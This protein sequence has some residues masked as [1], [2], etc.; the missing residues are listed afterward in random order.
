MQ[1]PLRFNA[2]IGCGALLLATTG[3]AANAPSAARQLHERIIVLDTHLDTPAL[4]ARPGWDIMGRHAFDSDRSQV[5]FPRMEEGGL[6]G[7]FWAIFTPQGP[8]TPAGN[9]AA[10]TRALLTA[11]RI[12]EMVAHNSDRFELAFTADDAERIAAAGKRIVYQSIENGYPLGQDLG[13]LETFYALGVRMV[14]VT[15]F[16]NNDLGDSATDPAGPEW[17]GLSPLGRTLVQEANRLGMLLDASHAS[18]AV[19]EQMIELSK[20]PVILSHSGCKAIHDN[21]RNIDDILLRKL[22]AAGGVIQI[23]SLSDYMIDTP[24]NPEREE[25]LRQLRARFGTVMDESQ[26]VELA[27]GRR[28]IDARYPVPTATFDDFMKHLL[29][30]LE[31]AGPEHVGIGADWDGGG[32]VTGMWEVSSIPKITEGLLAAGYSEADLRNI[33]SGNVIRLMQAA[34]DYVEKQKRGPGTGRFAR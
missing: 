23:N 22:A 15:H 33:W 29:H 16:T 6:D 19:L 21:P 17:K 20:T 25:A 28:E 13:L 24:R 12:R 26:A 14:G 31:I 11:T 10:R 1:P 4:F 2:L 5:D 8:R 30:A 18:D 3:L 27:T 7:G 9:A 34:E 32:G